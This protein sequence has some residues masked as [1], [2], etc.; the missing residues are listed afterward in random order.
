VNNLDS[1]LL[2]HPVWRGGGR[3]DASLPAMP[4]GFAELD[5]EL[6][7][8]GWPVGG[9]V[10]ILCAGEGIGELQLMLPALAALAAAGRRIAWIAPP[11]LPYAPA[12]AAAGIDLERLV[13]VRAPGRRD[14]LW[15][16]EQV[17]RA[18]ACHAAFIWLRD[19]RYTELRRLALAAGGHPALALLFRPAQAAGET[20]PA[21]LRLV[22]E[23][24]A[25]KLGARIL[26]RRGAPAAAALGIPIRRP[27]HA[28]GGVAFPPPVARSP[29]ARPCI[30]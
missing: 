10:E 24:V 15:A 27:V 16:M 21:C 5:R 11:H 3:G 2:S 4:T 25:G 20:S 28:V 17:L 19:V 18:G 12:L 29:V 13:V 14:A 8:G 23:P 6:P 7:G 9:L 1:I 22:L 26:K 30:V